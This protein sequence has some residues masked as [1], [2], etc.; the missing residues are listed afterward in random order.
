MLRTIR[1]SL[2]LNYWFPSYVC[3]MLS[4][5][6]ISV[7]ERESL[8]SAAVYRWPGRRF[9][10][11]DL[12][13]RKFAGLH[14]LHPEVQLIKTDGLRAHTCPRFVV[15]PGSVDVAV[16]NPPYFNLKDVKPYR[17]LLLD[18]GL[19][20][21][22]GL[23]RLTSE[24][25][26]LAQN[27]RLLREGGELG[28]ILPD[29]LIS[30]H[31]FAPLRKDLIE[32]HELFGVI[33]MPVH[34]FR[35][36]E[37]KTHILLLRRRKS[38]SPHIPLYEADC[39]MNLGPPINI[40]T[41]AA[42]LRMDARFWSWKAVNPSVPCQTLFSISAEIKRGTI[43]RQ[44]CLQKGLRHFHTGDFPDT[45]GL[46]VFFSHLES[47]EKR[48][49]RKGDILLA[50][51]GSRCIGRLAVVARGSR[52]ITDCVYRIRVS[53]AHRDIVLGAMASNKGQQW[54]KAHA[55]GVCAQ[56]ISKSDL[57]SFPIAAISDNP[58][59]PA[60]SQSRG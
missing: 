3:P 45:S 49:A 53:V 18:A 57:L 13:S 35:S 33:Q 1:N 11:A 44:E 51:V 19:S 32:C 28:I 55:H 58:R 38:R 50:R 40:P 10:A 39:Q 31:A 12:D 56:V 15:E 6:L 8:L 46:P 22:A 30:G 41:S 5:S 26:F 24:V 25:V 9:I 14:D 54:F 60:K 36:T 7:W 37:A 29:R 47:T 43:A 52:P 48:V 27:L 23:N 42:P 21:C 20:R 59:D 4:T 16:C 17:Q 34:I 2:S